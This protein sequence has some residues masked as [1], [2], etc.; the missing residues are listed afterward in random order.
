MLH[1]EEINPDIIFPIFEG[2]ND[3]S[4]KNVGVFDSLVLEEPQE[5]SN[6][7]L[8]TF[9]VQGTEKFYERL[10]NLMQCTPQIG[11]NKNITN[12]EHLSV[13]MVSNHNFKVVLLA[14]VYVCTNFKLPLIYIFE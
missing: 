2:M 9:I 1:W 5:E 13:L 8:F 6:V 14:L 11:F 10:I 4:C 12:M 3:V 7:Q